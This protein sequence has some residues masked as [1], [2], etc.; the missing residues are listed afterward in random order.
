[1]D[2]VAGG[3]VV[4]FFV[5][6][7]YLGIKALY[8]K[9]LDK[10]APDPY[11]K[12][13]ASIDY[14]LTISESGINESQDQQQRDISTGQLIGILCLLEIINTHSDIELNSEIRVRVKDLIKQI[15]KIAPDFVALLKLIKK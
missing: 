4:L 12:L 6:V 9:L 5:Y 3:I 14:L 15:T 10:F 8:K 13:E 1:M 2:Y 7:F 11:T